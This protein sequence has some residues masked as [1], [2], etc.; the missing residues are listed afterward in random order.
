MGAVSDFV[1]FGSRRRLRVWALAIATALAGT[2]ALVLAGLVP[3]DG[4]PYLAPRLF[5]LGA[6]LG[7]LLFGHGMV[8]AGGRAGRALGRL[9]GGG[10]EGLPGPLRVGV[11][12]LL[13][14]SRPAP[15]RTP[16]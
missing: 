16:G 5:W 12:G 6:I 1:L 2:Q 7:G 3:I 14:A 11:T 10:V 4:S 9:G 15:V 8:L 13:G